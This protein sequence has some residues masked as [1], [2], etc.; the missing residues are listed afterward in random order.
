MNLK[1]PYG[2]S[3]YEKIVNDGYYYVDKTMYIE[4]LENLPETSIIFLR[5]RKFGK[6]LF[7]SVLENYYDKNKAD[8]FEKL[9]GNKYIG[10]NPTENKNKYCILRFNF[11]GIDTSSEE[12]TIRGFKNS[13]IESI[14]LFIGNYNIDFYINENQEAEEILNSLFTAFL[15]QKKEELIYVIIDE[16]DHFAN[17]LLG[18][19]PERFKTLVSKNGKVRKWYEILKKGT[20]TIVDRIFITG[21]APITLDSLTSGFNIGTDITRDIDFNDM[22]GFTKNELVD[23][24]N[25]QDISKEEQEEILPIM[26]ENYDGYKFSL[27]AE[28]Q[29]YNSNM[30]LYFLSRYIR[31]KE[32]PNDLIDMNIASDYS[33]IG[34]MLDLCK[35]EKRLE[36]LR[37]TV[38][39]ETIT[40]TIVEKFNPAIEFTEIDMIS[41]LYYLGYLTISGNLAGIPE[42]VIPNKVM[43]E[44]Y[45]SYFLQLMNEEAEFRI[46][47]S[48][49]QEILIQ[50]AT[51]GRIDKI[52]EVLRIY[53]NNLSNRDLI[54]FDEKYIKLIF[55]CIVMNIG[56][57]STK[58]E[59]E[60]NR[61]Y[62]DILLVPRDRTKGYKAIMVE[63]KY[64]KKGEK[65]KVEDKQ[66]EAREQIKRYCQFEDIKDIEGLRKYTLVVSP[67]EIY[68]E[69]I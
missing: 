1:M 5:P 32:I 53:L 38:Q 68:V 43:K 6:T 3:N 37:K 13:T 59:M 63:F 11:S 50:L 45:A 19:Y 65:A 55:Y 48:A 58:S 67:S 17:E 7:T 15:L 39:G 31:L 30:C 29:I 66:K 2:I 41:M 57:Y 64:I 42:L 20:E 47:S 12:A 27:N 44:I 22:M 34:K 35:G 61:N 25:N 16:Y 21:V 28:N 54:K 4:K 46:D 18:F 36:I 69:E 52:V 10:K 8:K 14:K 62:P 49:S 33:K 24:L 9:Y 40:N 23:I 26:K 51:E 56:S 60:V